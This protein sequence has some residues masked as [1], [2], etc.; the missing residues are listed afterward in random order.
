MAK[1]P[2]SGQ[3]LLRKFSEL[4]TVILNQFNP[5]LKLTS[6]KLFNLLTTVHVFKHF[7]LGKQMADVLLEIR[8][9]AWT[10][11]ETQRLKQKSLKLK[12]AKLKILIE[13]A[14]TPEAKAIAIN[15]LVAFA[16]EE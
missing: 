8:Q 15:N 7:A 16:S 14:P 10:A 1:K 2:L 5:K 3:V 9:H 11:K 4:K 13:Y 6:G 12:T